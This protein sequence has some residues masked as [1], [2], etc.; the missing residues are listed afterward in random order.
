MTEHGEEIF[1]LPIEW[2]VPESV[3][4]AYATGLVVQHTEHEFILNFFRAQPPIAVGSPDQIRAQMEHTESVRAE[5]VAR[6][7]VAAGRMPEFMAVLQRN[8]ENYLR[9]MDQEE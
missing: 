9:R 2:H 5:C 3:G 6:V 8:L 1:A 7:V 4:C